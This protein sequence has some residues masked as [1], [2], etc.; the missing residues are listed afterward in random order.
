MMSGVAVDRPRSIFGSRQGEVIA[1]VLLALAILAAYATVYGNAFLYDDY[2]L[3]VDNPLIQSWHSLP[4]LFAAP[5]TDVSR[6]YRPLQNL[7][8]LVL[9]QTT[10]LS[11]PAFH[12]LN[13]ALHVLNACLIYA[14]GIKMGFKRGAVLLATLIWA[15]HPVQTEAVTYMSATADLLYTA[16]SL[17]GILAITPMA[18]TRHYGVA[19]VFLVLACLSKESAISF[20]LLVAAGFYYAK[21]QRLAPRSY[22][23]AWP[24]FLITGL[25]GAAR[26]AM[27]MS[28]PIATAAAASVAATGNVATTEYAFFAVLSMYARLL[29]WPFGLHMEHDLPAYTHITD[30]AVLIGIGVIVAVTVLILR[31]QTPRSLPLSWGILWFFAALFPVLCIDGILYEH[32]LYLPSAGLLLGAM[33]SLALQ[34]EKIPMAPKAV[35][36]LGFVAALGFLTFRQNEIWHD[37]VTFYTNTFIHG[38]SAPKAHAALGAYYT[39]N[40]DPM[41]G[42]EQ[43]SLAID[44]ASPKLFTAADSA[45]TEA[46]WGIALMM[47]GDLAADDTAEKH[48]HR[49]LDADPNFYPALHLLADIYTQRGDKAQAELYQSRA[50]AVRSVQP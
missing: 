41:G 20:P 18:T 2:L 34:V 24:F 46:N 5:L 8:Y 42:I 17:M 12:A 35:V 16:F 9:F 31:P 45:A 3:I 38:E 11:L 23:S 49:A 33:Q 19:C 47:M 4:H 22:V 30:G 15:L 21:D 14:L 36:G 44:L 29:F 25:Y 32:W 10:G 1:C 26:V 6:Y 43:D 40:N 48:F 37:P 13:V 27:M 28:H 39:Q 7:A 50:A